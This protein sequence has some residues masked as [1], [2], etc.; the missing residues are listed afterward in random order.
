MDA[1]VRHVVR[2]QSVI[3]PSSGT[4]VS[5]ARGVF[6]ESKEVPRRLLD[7]PR[8]ASERAYALAAQVSAA[9]GP[10]GVP[11]NLALEIREVM[12]PPPARR[13]LMVRA[14]ND[15]VAHLLRETAPQVLGALV[16]VT[17]TE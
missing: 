5:V 6:P 16:L 7:R 15:S 9:P 1:S 14:A 3:S 12:F 4:T 13:R 17:A 8:R 10:C 2:H 11:L